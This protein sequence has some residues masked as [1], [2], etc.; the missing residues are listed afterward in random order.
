MISEDKNDN[1]DKKFQNE[2]TKTFKCQK[3]KSAENSRIRGEKTQ[4]L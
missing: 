2:L 3:G 4:I 1:S